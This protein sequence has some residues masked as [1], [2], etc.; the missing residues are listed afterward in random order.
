M[1]KRLKHLEN[2]IDTLYTNID[3]LETWVNHGKSVTME[4]VYLNE[5]LSKLEWI[6]E[7]LLKHLKLEEVKENIHELRK[8][9]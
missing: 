3:D 9:K 4:R 5:R 1:F 6:C 7:E 2:K 8:Q